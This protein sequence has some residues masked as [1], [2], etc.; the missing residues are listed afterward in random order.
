MDVGTRETQVHVGAAPRA[1]MGEA[2]DLQSL[3]RLVAPDFYASEPHD[4]YARLRREAPVFW[5][6]E[7]SIWG[8][9]K[10]ED[11]KFVHG[12]PEL[13]SSMYGIM[14]SQ[15][16]EPDDG[17][18]CPVNGLPRMAELRRKKMLE[19][20][21][22]NELVLALD[23]P[24]HTRIRR[25]VSAAFTPRR[26]ASLEPGIRALTREALALIEPGDVTDLIPT[27]AGPIPLRTIAQMLGVP[28]EDWER[29]GVW[30]D[31]ITAGTSGIFNA[32]SP[33]AVEKMEQFVQFAMYFG[34]QLAERKSSPRDDLLTALQQEVD[35]DVLNDMDQ[36][37]NCV[38]LLTA[39][40]ET[41]RT[42]IAGG[43]KLLAEN[44][45]QCA[46][47]VDHPET[48]SWAVEEMLRCVTPVTGFAR[49]A[50]ETTT[51]R[52]EEIKRGD[53]VMS[54]F[55]SANRDEEAWV[56]PDVF[57]VQRRPDPGHV[58]F[59]FGPHF[60]LGAALARLEAKVVFEELLSSF[61]KFELAG[62]SRRVANGDVV[63]RYTSMPMV[64]G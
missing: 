35:G 33:E 45:D 50:M 48:I 17:S 56:D 34:N 31:A 53:Y 52:G 1:L 46:W 36:L 44:P 29:F 41:T 23:P 8:L 7:G 13:F 63:P 30:S 14:P 42:L 49:T 21:A 62:E 15:A 51:I 5:S 26:V 12:H 22:G 43:A 61:P 28:R 40:N 64:F 38:L 16:L 60:C 39:G 3:A 6:E 25:L 10:Y 59:G 47:L 11:V 54:L 24:R 57:D 9:S 2:E 27:L 4:I 32:D 19:M 37:A 20:F 58:A 18:A 55:A